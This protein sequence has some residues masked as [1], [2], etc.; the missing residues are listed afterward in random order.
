MRLVLLIISPFSYNISLNHKLPPTTIIWILNDFIL[1]DEEDNTDYFI[2][3]LGLWLFEMQQVSWID[4]LAFLTTWVF[5]SNSVRVINYP[6]KWSIPS[7]QLNTIK[8]WTL[9]EGVAVVDC[10][11]WSAFLVFSSQFNPRNSTSSSTGHFEIS[12]YVCKK[13]SS[14]NYSTNFTRFY[15]NLHF[16]PLYN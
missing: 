1:I 6:V 9:N 16:I 5:C 10:R 11:C 12:L 7:L 13:L 4:S 8:N 3:L 15:S 14:F 2:W